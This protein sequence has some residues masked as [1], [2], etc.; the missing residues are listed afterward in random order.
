MATNGQVDL[1]CLI[2]WLESVISSN[3]Y[4]GYMVIRPLERAPIGR[5]VFGIPQYTEF[6]SP[7]VLVRAQYETHLLG[8]QLKVEG[9]P[10]MQQDA[11]VGACAHVS[12]WMAARH[13]HIKHRE[14]WFSTVDIAERASN[15]TDVT[16][17]SSLPS[18]SGGLNLNNMIRA[19][20]TMG[21]EPIVYLANEQTAQDGT[22]SYS[23]PEGLRPEEVVVRYIDSG[24]PV[25]LAIAPWDSSQREGHAVTC[26][27]HVQ[28]TLPA[29]FSPMRQCTHAIFCDA[30]LV[31]DDQR[32]C[33]L[34]MPIS[35][36]I[37]ESNLPY[38]V[39]PNVYGILISLPSRVY[40]K[41]E[42]A[43]AIAWNLVSQFAKSAEKLINIS[44]SNEDYVRM[45]LSAIG[46]N[47]LIARTYLTPG[48][49]Y[50]RRIYNNSLCDQAKAILLKLDL[51]RFVWVTE[52][53]LFSDLNQTKVLS[54]K[55][56]SHVVVDATTGEYW[57][58]AQLVF[59]APGFLFTWSHDPQD[60]CGS[61]QQRIWAL[62]TDNP[63]APRVR[64]RSQSQ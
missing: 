12:I 33:Y 47:L 45:Y 55:I 51:P 61:Y 2:K 15:P 41:A 28:V 8:A 13:L 53:G 31:N 7:N 10:F 16:L 39:W 11:R 18:G 63:Y 56:I 17:A 22:S 43:E 14:G 40:I 58:S 25:I 32:G 54:R 38:S 21:R 4:L 20:R 23:W 3:S 36:G 24:I 46:N 30:L 62:S 9:T 64:G 49:K 26:F 6:S 60:E 5:S 42:I 50:K 52:Y 29:S 59:H 44:K 48:W 57:R 34:R 19:I 35:A 27:G 37:G 1:I